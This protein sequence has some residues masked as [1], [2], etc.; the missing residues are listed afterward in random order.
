YQPRSGTITFGAGTTSLT[1]NVPVN[2]DTAAEGAETFLLNLT[3]VSKA[4]LAN[5]HGTAFV[6]DADPPPAPSG[7]GVTTTEGQSGTKTMGFTVTLSAASTQTVTVQ[8][9]TA[10]GT[11][12]AGS[13]YTG[14]TELVTFTPGQTSK[15]VNVTVTGDTVAEATETYFLNLSA[16]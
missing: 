10:D 2:G 4:T 15:V 14:K 9:T 5:D 8:A 16:P 11:A 7:R 6:Y 3:A 12:T 1:L 13:D